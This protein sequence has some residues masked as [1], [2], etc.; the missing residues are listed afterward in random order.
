MPAGGIDL[1][2]VGLALAASL[3]RILPAEAGIALLGAVAAGQL[4]LRLIGWWSRHL[5]PQAP[6][7]VV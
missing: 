7:P 6:A 2:D 5:R 3:M 4:C 1:D